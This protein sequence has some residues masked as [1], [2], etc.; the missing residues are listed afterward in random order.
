MAKSGIS[1]AAITDCKYVHYCHFSGRNVLTGHFSVH[2]CYTYLYTM[3]SHPWALSVGWINSVEDR[4]KPLMPIKAV[5][6]DLFT[7]WCTFKVWIL[8]GH[9]LFPKE[10]GIEG[11]YL[12]KLSGSVYSSTKLCFFNCVTQLQLYHHTYGAVEILYREG[13]NCMSGWTG[14]IFIFI[15]LVHA[16]GIFC[17]LVFQWA[18]WV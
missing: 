3:C 4:T 5:S 18:F 13:S 7:F 14:T 1:M 12:P 16:R 15:T 17:L 9:S 8:P 11:I 6:Q 2:T 10:K